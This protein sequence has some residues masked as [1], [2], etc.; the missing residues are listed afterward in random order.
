MQAL[1]RLPRHQQKLAAIIGEMAPVLLAGVTS[2]GSAPPTEGDLLR[3]K[4]LRIALVCFGGVSLAVYMHGISKEIL[5][6]VRA[7]SALHAITDRA[8]RSEASFFECVDAANPEYDTEAVYFELLREI[9]CKLELR[10]IVDVIAGASA[11]GINGTMLARALAHD[12]PMGKLRDLWLQNAD[13]TVL[14]APE[15]KAGI[16]SKWILKP[17]IW[18]AA[19]T[20]FLKAIKD[21]EVRNKLSL[22]VRSRWFK[23]PLDGSRM[24]ELMYDAIVAMGAPKQPSSSLLPR[25]QALDLFVTVTDYHGYQHLVPIHDPPLI[26]EQEHHR[27]LSFKCRRSLSGEVESDFELGNAPALAF[28]ARATSSFP[29]A[30]PPAQIAETDEIVRRKRGAWPGRDAFIQR[31]FPADG[32]HGIDPAKVCFIDGSVLNNRPFR[33]AIS[34]IHGRPAY[35]QIDRRLVYI[36]P[37]PVDDPSAAQ[38]TVPGFFST[39]KGALSDIPRNQPVTDELSWILDFNNQARHLRS[40]VEGARPHV[41]R[42]VMDIVAEPP[43]RPW[44]ADQIRAWR[45]R[46]NNHVAVDAGFAY[47]GYVRLKLATVRAF[48]SRLVINLRGV[49]E[50][51]PHAQAIADIIDAWA[52]R[53]GIVYLG[54]GEGRAGHEENPKETVPRWLKFFLAFDVDYRRRRLQ[55]LIEGQNRLYQMLDHERFKNLDPALVDSLKRGFYERLEWL[56]RRED[57]RFFSAETH[58]IVS[59]IFAQAPTADDVKHRDRYAQRFAETHADAIE[60]LVDRLSAEI[61]LDASTRDIDELLATLDHTRWNHDARREILVNHLG[62]PFW[63]VLTL[64]TL[65]SRDVGEFQEILVD[66]ISPQ[67]ARTLKGFNG[68]QS[69]KGIGFGHFA[70]FLSRSYRENDYLLGRLH[71]ADRL[72]DIICDSAGIDAATDLPGIVALKKRAFTQILRAEKKYLVES[73]ALIAELQRVVDAMA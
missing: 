64:P 28:A 70:A 9:G 7:S 73:A 14:L 47:Q 66:R 21:I 11:G 69:L 59:Q 10:V 20:G 45:E 39:L 52:I 24:A 49:P 71:S 43:D 37:D 8:E 68:S 29:G 35:R 15:A 51:S 60:H 40:I 65:V 4:E 72:I 44:T 67:D 36:D 6:V 17:L 54:N 5:K 12:L 27:V 56:R 57:A 19:V 22:F 50:R 1:I 32:A 55:F 26:R 48:I 16:W 42:L 3:E 31:N 18:G 25:G 41:H 33:E 34:A 63:D 38:R 61:D 46:V 62:F 53:A 58:A 2:P 23:P 13:V 30:F